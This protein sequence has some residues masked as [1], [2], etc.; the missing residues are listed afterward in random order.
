MFTIPGIYGVAHPH[1]LQALQLWMEDVTSRLQ[2]VIA[3]P[4]RPCV[5]EI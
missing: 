4:L 2:Q 3:A 1:S 5:A